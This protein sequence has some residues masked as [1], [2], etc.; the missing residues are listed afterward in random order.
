MD[1]YRLLYLVMLTSAYWLERL[2]KFLGGTIHNVGSVFLRIYNYST[3]NAVFKNR[4]SIIDA[5]LDAASN[6]PK[7]K[8]KFVQL[9]EL[10]VPN[11]IPLYT[12][13]VGRGI[14]NYQK[15][16]ELLNNERDFQKSGFYN[17]CGFSNCID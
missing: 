1:H 9:S 11:L 10:S 5:D 4:A 7:T 2:K 15:K 8:L 3:T 12:D 14:L 13:K 17:R 16:L 6:S